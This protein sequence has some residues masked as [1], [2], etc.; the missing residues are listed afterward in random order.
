MRIGYSVEGST[1]RALLR[2]LQRRWCPAAEMVEGHFRGSTGESLRRELLKI[3]GEFA[4]KSVDAMVFLMDA[5]D[6][7]WRDVQKEARDRFPGDRLAL[8]VLGVADRNVECW[9]CLEADYVAG[10]LGVPAADLRV[11]DPKGR[12]ESAMGIDRDDRKEAKIEDLVKNAPLHPLASR[13]LVQ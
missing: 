6:R 5:N 12:F 4:F 13:S 1:D 7:Q 8:A 3:C 9:I 11:P 10:V 2:G